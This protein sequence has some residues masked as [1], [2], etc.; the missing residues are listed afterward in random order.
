MPSLKVGNKTFELEIGPPTPELQQVA[1]KELRE[2]PEVQ[3]EAIARLKEL[4][5]GFFY[6]YL[7]KET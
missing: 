3:K 5:K 4:L 1:Q 7:Y 2:S 6:I